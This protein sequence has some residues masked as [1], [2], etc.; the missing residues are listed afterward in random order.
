M[1]FFTITW[2]IQLNRSFIYFYKH[3]KYYFKY[4]ELIS[5]RH[6]RCELHVQS[7][8]SWYCIVSWYF[9]QW[10]AYYK[11]AISHIPTYDIKMCIA[12]H[13]KSSYGFFCP[14][15]SGI[16]IT[17]HQS[18]WV[19]RAKHKLESNHHSKYPGQNTVRSSRMWTDFIT[20]I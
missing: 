15:W 3:F 13:I 19:N 18:K 4:H 5:M 8:E 20:Y 12:V 16:T 6:K 1:I 11:L 14:N 7:P 17:Q 9:W 2:K 10:Y